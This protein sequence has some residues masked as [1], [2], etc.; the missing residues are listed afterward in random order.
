MQDL[1]EHKPILAF[2]CEADLI[3][4][5]E[6]AARL[7]GISRSA[8]ARRALKRDLARTGLMRALLNMDSAA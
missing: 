5:A 7:E 8:L 4:L 1:E 6:A 2:R 3:A